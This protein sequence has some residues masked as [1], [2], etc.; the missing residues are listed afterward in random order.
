MI[1]LKNK[2][3]K[4]Y[5]FLKLIICLNPIFFSFFVILTGF[6]DYKG[7]FE[8]GDY[9][10]IAQNWLN[11]SFDENPLERLPLYPFLLLLYLRYSEIIT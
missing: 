11:D 9:I 1:Q 4:I 5:K 7:I 10:N 2:H 8:S 6:I 3:K